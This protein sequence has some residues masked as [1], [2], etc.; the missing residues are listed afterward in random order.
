MAR[1]GSSRAASRNARRASAWLNAYDRFEA[2][3]HEALRLPVARRH[4]ER[5]GAEILQARRQR[6]GGRRLL[7][8][9]AEVVDVAARGRR[10]FW[11]ALS[12]GTPASTA[13]PAA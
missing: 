2:L 13:R 4:R 9:A 12:C 5:V 11:P 6:A 8:R 10:A 7:R 3:I 1:F